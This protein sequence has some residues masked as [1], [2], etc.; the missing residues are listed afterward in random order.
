MTTVCPG[1]VRTGSPLNALFKGKHRQEYAWFATGDVTPIISISAMRLA[2]RIVDAA[3][4]AR[5][6]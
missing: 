6:N 4:E 1:L 5:A 3:Q 2:R